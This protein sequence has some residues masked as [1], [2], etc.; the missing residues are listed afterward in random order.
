MN[1]NAFID[2]AAAF[3]MT[4]VGTARRLGIAE[5]NWV[6]LHGCADANSP[7]RLGTHVFRMRRGAPR[8]GAGLSSLLARNRPLESAKPAKGQGLKD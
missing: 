1:S 3:I 4:S 2:Q 7:P 5:A 6:F 8:R